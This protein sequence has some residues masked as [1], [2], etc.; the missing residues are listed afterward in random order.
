MCDEVG[1]QRVKDNQVWLLSIELHRCCFMG[2][3]WGVGVVVSILRACLVNSGEN[4][5]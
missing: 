1:L 2:E 5:K 3:S 4:D